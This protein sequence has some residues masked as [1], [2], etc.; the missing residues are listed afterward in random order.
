MC[1]W[2]LNLIVLVNYVMMKIHVH[3]GLTVV[4]TSF[5]VVCSFASVVMTTIH[6]V[7]SPHFC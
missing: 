4:E 6:R 3:S 2:M 7:Y 1:H 5:K